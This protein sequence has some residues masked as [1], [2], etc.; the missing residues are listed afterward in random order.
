MAKYSIVMVR[1]GESE[2]NL[3]NLFCGWYD[4]ELSAKG[5]YSLFSF[6][7]DFTNWFTNLFTLKVTRRLKVLVRLWK[8]PA[9]NSISL[10]LPFLREPR[11]LCVTF[12]RLLVKQTFLLAKHG[13][14]TNVITVVSLAWIKLK[15]LQSMEKIRYASDATNLLLRFSVYSWVVT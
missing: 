9:T 6:A 13:G 8:M 7:Y 10:I 1:H 2:W 14:W 4:A 11:K 5:K 15:Q 3:K 12:W